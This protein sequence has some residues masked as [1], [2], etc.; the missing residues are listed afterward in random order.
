M[1]AILLVAH[2][3]KR[4]ES[5]EE[6]INLA[7]DLECAPSINAGFV[8]AAF[9]DIA[10]PSIPDGIRECV[11]QGATS[12]TIIPYFLNSGRHVT[13]DIPNVVNK[14]KEEIPDVRIRIAPHIGESGLIK[15]L[16]IKIAESL[17]D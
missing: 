7:R 6:V 17:Q 8:H 9:L 10:T 13:I 5:N 3:S 1:K 16:L 12:I 2:G 14:T 4:A 15:D 11:N